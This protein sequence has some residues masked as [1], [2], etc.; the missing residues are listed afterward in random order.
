MGENTKIEWADHTASF[1][2]G[3]VKVSPG[4]AHC[5][6]ESFEKR[7]G[8]DVWGKLKPRKWTKGGPALIRKLNKK[9]AAAG[10]IDTVFVNDLGD[11]FE[12]FAGPVVDHQGHRVFHENFGYTVDPE[13]PAQRDNPC[14]ISDLR[15]DAFR[16]FDQCQ[17]LIFML[18]TKRPENIRRMWPRNDIESIRDRIA[19]E[20]ASLTEQWTPAKGFSKYRVSNLGRVD[21]PR[22]IL[23]G[24]VGEKGHTRVTLQTDDNR[25]DRVLVQWS[26]EPG[27]RHISN[28]WLGTSCSDQPTFDVAWR[29]L[30]KCTD[31][32]P[33]RFFSLEP[34]LGPIN[35]HE[36]LYVG[37]EGGAEYAGG[38]RN[39]FQLAI[40]GGESGPKARPCRVDWI[41]DIGRQCQAAGV[42]WF[43]KQLG[44]RPVW[45]M[46]KTQIAVDDFA[47]MPEWGEMRDPKGGNMDEWPEDLRVRQLPLPPRKLVDAPTN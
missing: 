5:Y 47:E 15:A 28:C 9:A 16:L 13:F 29:E 42:A 19:A 46:V 17:N 22:G 36:A 45:P 30:A 39:F 44:S 7:V 41:R 33:V 21:G 10:R 32:C 8:N 26:T 35:M 43:N 20:I 11:F 34:L 3:C 31:L 37:E 24:D 23:T 38:R 25:R 1:W 12:D 40:T 27:Y 6:A 4:C 14:L 18:L 2:E